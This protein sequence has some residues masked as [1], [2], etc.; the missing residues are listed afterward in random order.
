MLNAVVRLFSHMDESAPAALPRRIYLTA[1]LDDLRRKKQQTEA[2][3][4]DMPAAKFNKSG[5]V[6]ADKF[7][8]CLLVEIVSDYYCENS[9]EYHYFETNKEFPLV[10]ATVLMSEKHFRLGKYQRRQQLSKT[11]KGTGIVIIGEIQ[12]VQCVV[13]CESFRHGVKF[14]CNAFLGSKFE[15]ANIEYSEDQQI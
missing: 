3:S 5:W 10:D 12:D 11:I 13:G 4:Q 15:I 9:K 8:G 1:C 6:I 2:I 7:L 14:R